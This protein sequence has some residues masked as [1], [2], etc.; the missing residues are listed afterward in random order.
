MIP[1]LR[2]FIV[3]L[4]V[5][6][7]A[8]G[9]V[10]VELDGGSS[11]AASPA[12]TR[13][14]SIVGDPVL[15]LRSAEEARLM[16]RLTDREGLPMAGQGVRFALDGRAHDSTLTKLSVATDADGVAHTTLVAG[17]AIAAFRVRAS[18]VDAASVAFDVAIG[19]AGFGRLSVVPIY[20]GERE[21]ARVLAGV[22][23]DAS[24]SDDRARREEGDRVQVLEDQ[25]EDVEILRFLGLPVGISYAVTVRGESADGT[26]VAWGCIDGVGVSEGLSSQVTVAMED[27]SLQ[28]EGSYDTSV[29]VQSPQTANAVAAAWNRAQD[30]WVT[31]SEA[32][33]L[34][35]TVEDHLRSTSSDDADDFAAA[36]SEA[37]DASYQAALEGA[38]AGIYRGFD[39]AI[40]RAVLNLRHVGVT[41]T[42]RVSGDTVDFEAK[43]I[44][45]G[46][47][48]PRWIPLAETDLRLETR[49][50][51]TLGEEQIV[52]E[53]MV[54]EL[55]ISQ[56]LTLLIEAQAGDEGFEQPEQQ[57]ASDMGCNRL[58]ALPASLDRYCD[59]D[60]L[61]DACLQEAQSIYQR[62]LEE[63]APFDRDRAE[64][65][66]AGGAM[67]LDVRGNLQ[68]DSIEGEVAGRWTGASAR[69]AEQVVGTFA[70]DRINP[71]E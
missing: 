49:L 45:G 11:D 22:F 17:T 54:V 13:R 25:E 39:A 42:L 9:D 7:A 71:P 68:A 56:V 57:L 51:A 33:T 53:R 8:C 24:C 69:V 37:G 3:G 46:G 47:S 35:D 59:E 20:G 58:P 29:V 2:F 31:T 36:R 26:L 27:L 41:G 6:L 30:D 19:N 14:L 5:M 1:Y 15:S 65:V 70:G 67:L 64:L 55:P 28:L 62:L 66:L 61:A 44:G 12:A 16:V 60:C 32:A 4:C 52:I 40:Q 23:V 34:L 50:V 18:A 21:F 10:H 63:L 43:A 38:M 48:V